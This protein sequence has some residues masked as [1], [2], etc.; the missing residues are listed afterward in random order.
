MSRCLKTTGL[1]VHHKDRSGGNDLANALVLCEE[2][3]E[4]T[5][6]YGEQGTS[7]PDFTEE[8]KQQALRRAGNQCQCVDGQRGCHIN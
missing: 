2:C 1:E 4:K 3:H 6:S 5:P 7:P 8:T